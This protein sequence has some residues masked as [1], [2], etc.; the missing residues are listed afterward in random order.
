MHLRIQDV[1][2]VRERVDH[3][4]KSHTSWAV[5]FSDGAR[6]RAFTKPGWAELS[7]HDEFRTQTILD[8]PEESPHLHVF[9]EA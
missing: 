9:M 4:G 7:L 3:Y 5:T 8:S 2:I 6:G 1:R